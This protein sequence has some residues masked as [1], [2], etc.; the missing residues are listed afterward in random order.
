MDDVVGFLEHVS[1]ILIARLDTLREWEQ[2]VRDWDQ[3]DY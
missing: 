3:L 1:E 2:D